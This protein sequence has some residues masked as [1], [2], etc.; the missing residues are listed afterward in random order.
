MGARITAK[1]ATWVDRAAEKRVKDFLQNPP[2]SRQRVPPH[3][4]HQSVYKSHAHDD[5]GSPEAVVALSAPVL[6]LL[7]GG[8]FA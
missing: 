3:D 7:T 5:R 2:G 1:R 6:L 4:A 8:L